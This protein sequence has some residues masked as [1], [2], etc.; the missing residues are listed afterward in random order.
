MVFATVAMYNRVME[1]ISTDDTDALKRMRAVVLDSLTSKESK[2]SYERSI[3]RYIK[4]LNAERPTTGFTKATVQAFRAHLIASGLA[5][6]TVN[7]F[8]T[9]LRRLAGEAADNC[10]LPSEIAAGIGRVRGMRREGVR[11][12]NW[13][14]GPE[15]QHFLDAPDATC[16]FGKLA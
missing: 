8:L 5:S 6:S 10:L 11:I 9:A 16:P 12:G 1:T 7:L 13:L 15:A 14:T 4:W 2:R 3:N